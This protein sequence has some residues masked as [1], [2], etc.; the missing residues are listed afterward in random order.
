MQAVHVVSVC[1]HMLAH[2]QWGWCGNGFQALALRQGIGGTFVLPAPRPPV[3]PCTQAA[4][5]SPPLTLYP[6]VS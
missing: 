3:Q 4:Y 1:V 6:P 5:T 2:A